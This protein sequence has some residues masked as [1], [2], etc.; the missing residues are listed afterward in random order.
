MRAIRE[1]PEVQRYDAWY[2]DHPDEALETRDRAAM[3]RYNS[4]VADLYEMVTRAE[5]L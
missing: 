5:D 4:R 1:H 2:H 3:R